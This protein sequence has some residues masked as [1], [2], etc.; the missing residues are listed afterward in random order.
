MGQ[1]GYL[2]ANLC[3]AVSGLR[4]TAVSP[5]SP[6]ERARLKDGDLIVGYAGADLSGE[7]SRK[8]LLWDVRGGAGK[9]LRLTVKREGKTVNLKVVPAKKD[10]YPMDELYAALQNRAFTGRL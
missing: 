7:A 10:L 3:P 5:G 4:A 2:G 8:S 9:T 6:A 1:A